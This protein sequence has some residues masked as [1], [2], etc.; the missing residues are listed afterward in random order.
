MNRKLQL[1]VLVLSGAILG[2]RAENWIKPHVTGM[3]QV[4]IR[5]EMQRSARLARES[6]RCIDW[7]YATRHEHL[8]WRSPLH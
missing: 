2:I 8:S 3:D 7:A 6:H 4:S 5:A 1:M